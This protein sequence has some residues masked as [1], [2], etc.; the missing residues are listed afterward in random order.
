MDP[1]TV[2]KAFEKYLEK[3]SPLENVK[4]NIEG[5]YD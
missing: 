4:V 3:D 2:A 5:K 1:Q